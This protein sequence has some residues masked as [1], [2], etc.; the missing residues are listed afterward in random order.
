MLND[1]VLNVW[2]KIINIKIDKNYG[3]SETVFDRWFSL[4]KIKGEVII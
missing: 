1:I 3:I 4:Y 2:N